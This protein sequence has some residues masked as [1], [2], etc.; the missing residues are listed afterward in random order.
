MTESADAAGIEWFRPTSGRVMGL[1]GQVIAVCLVVAAVWYHREPFSAELGLAAVFGAVLVWSAI[2]R[3]RLGLSPSALVMH[4][5]LETVTIPLAAIEELSIRQ[6]TAVRAGDH[7]YISPAVGKSWRTL[8]RGDKTARRSDGLPSQRSYPD[9]VEERIRH[10]V[11]DARDLAGVRRGSA[12]QVALGKA[13]RREP[14][15]PEIV[16]LALS[17]VALVIAFLL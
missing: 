14:A 8:A 2:L 10:A 3:P 4:N 5:M 13:V 1:A 16:A 12:E 11:N 17:G 15:W 6:V 7:R 9:F